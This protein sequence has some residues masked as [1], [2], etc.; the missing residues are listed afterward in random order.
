MHVSA[1]ALAALDDQ[2]LQAPVDAFA[3]LCYARAVQLPCS[4]ESGPSAAVEAV[5]YSW[6]RFSRLRPLSP[7]SDIHEA[8]EEEEQEE[9]STDGSDT[10][11][12]DEVMSP[13]AECPAQGTITRPRIYSPTP[14]AHRDAHSPAHPRHYAHESDGSIQFRSQ[15]SM[16]SLFGLSCAPSRFPPG[17]SCFSSCC[18]RIAIFLQSSCIRTHTLTSHT[19]HTIDAACLALAAHK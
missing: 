10:D 8:E 19:P 13:D 1:G 3:D 9:E 5:P 16:R 11:G 15:V 14:H 12:D 6:R 18:A 7:F 17:P 2:L 4:S